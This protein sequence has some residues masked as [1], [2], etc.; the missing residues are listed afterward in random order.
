MS[1][2]SDPT[3]STASEDGAIA[4]P[5][6][7]GVGFPV[8]GLG[9]SAG[10]LQALIRFFELMPS[11]SG[12]AFVVVLHLSPRHESNLDQVLRGATRM[13]VMQVTQTVVIEKNCVYVISPAMRLTMLDGTLNVSPALEIAGRQTAIDLFFRTL[14]DAQKHHA[15]A[16]VLSGTGSDGAVGLKAVK[17]NGGVTIAQAPEDAL[18]DG[19]PRSAI[20]T[21]IID[22]VLPVSDMPQRL[23][24][25]AEN[26]RYI[27][28]PT[29]PE[30]FVTSSDRATALGDILSLLR[31]RTGHDFSQY[32][33]ATVL[34][35]LERR[36]QVTQTRDLAAYR[37]YLR[38]NASESQALLKD[39]LISVT[40][41]FRDKDAFDALEKNVLP[42]ICE[43]RESS[44]QVRIWVLGCATGEEAYSIAMLMAECASRYASPPQVQIFATDIDHDAIEVA[45]AGLYPEAIEAD[46][47]PERLKR[48]F[49]RE[50]NGYRISRAVRETVMFALHDVLKDPPF[51]RVD[52][53]ACRNL[54]I[55]LNS[56]VKT[57]VLQLLHFA[58]RPEGFLF[59]GNSEAIDETLGY[60][61]TFD[62]AARIYRPSPRRT[63]VTLP[64]LGRGVTAQT[65]DVT[66]PTGPRR[67]T[68][69]GELHHAMLEQY[70]PPS[71]IVNEQFDIVHLSPSSGRLLRFAGGEATLNLLKVVDDD[72]RVELRMG[73]YQALQTG[74]R[75]E[76]DVRRGDA[77]GKFVRVSIRPAVDPAT[78]RLFL[79]VIFHDT[80]ELHDAAA[81]TATTEATPVVDQLERELHAVRQQL[82]ATIDQYETQTEEL[83]ASNEELQ[84]INEELRSA[85]EELETGQEELQSTNEELH[86][87][88]QELKVRIEETTTTNNDLQNFIASTNIAVLFVNRDLRLMRFTPPAREIFNLLDGDVGRPLLDITS[89]ID[90]PQLEEDMRNVMASLQSNEREVVGDNGRA[91][92]ARTLPYRTTEDKID[93]A[94]VTFVEITARKG[95]EAQLRRN[96]ER[97]QLLMSSVRDYAMFTMAKDGSIDSWNAGAQR[98]FGWAEHEI[99]NQPAD[100]LF[101]PE[102]RAAGMP[103]EEMASAIENGRAA[104]ERF[105]VRKDGSR[106]YCSGIMTP[107]Y[108]GGTLYGFVKIARDIT[109]QHDAAQRRDEMLSAERINRSAAEQAIRTKDEFLATL[110]H[111]L[112]NPL[113][114]ILMQ[115]ELLLRASELHEVPKLKRA[116]EIIHQTVTA[117][118]Q[119]VDD[120][121]DMSRAKTGKLAINQQLLPLPFIIADSIGALKQDAELKQVALEMD[122]TAEPLIVAADAVRI[123]QIAWNLISNAIKFT[124]SGGRV[125][126][127]LRREANDARLDV[128]DT[129]QGIPPEM[130]AHIFDWF[131]Q[132]DTGS[133]RR[134]GGMGIGLALVR[135]LVELQGGRVAA[136]SEGKGKGA[137]FTVWMP[138]H[139]TAV[140]TA[141]ALPA[142]HQSSAE[143]KGT[144]LLLV[145]D[146]TAGANS[147]RDLLE[148]EGASVDAATSGAQALALAKDQ[149]YDI[150]ISD[151]E[152]PEMDG[153]TMLRRLRAYPSNKDT[154]AIAYTGYGRPQDLQRSKASGFNR[155]LTKPLDLTT[156]IEAIKALVK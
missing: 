58:L 80:P 26:A 9:A 94:V 152:M 2:P 104:D 134:Q 126:V 129:G 83:K 141:P 33:R 52:L 46:V 85:T 39:M 90:Y 55:Y 115:T 43:G 132:A 86:T 70:A 24:Q 109:E 36:M 38:A 92:L 131:R 151:I 123:K 28:L 45:R 82:R 156:L 50:P 153:H 4:A 135:Q 95:I 114:L 122:M 60:Y 103:Q 56:E 53:V 6:L 27:K 78:R 35:R 76:L 12:M 106:F 57:K 116:A 48:F 140:T 107:L 139:E 23:L 133:T 125:L 74:R 44:D 88:N 142:P 20:A 138:L 22:F 154:P 14:A 49:T 75:V 136:A 97:L 41:F 91:Y 3:E 47:S 11:D 63:G 99:L 77:T 68:T 54:L 31:T 32:K 96:D 69:Y 29:L 64:V 155:H 147:L 51:S 8:I 127:R 150:V 19:M 37:E 108:Y 124:S 120:L 146:S 21:R 15:M 145:D 100:V 73:L 7:P 16:I 98:I 149:H 79:L 13:P 61:V 130:L 143:L 72:L 144:R 10:G 119:L 66:T 62:K 84:A 89:R 111:E 128:E 25:I 113:S 105:H 71:V 81:S 101:T 93:G 30:A 1:E 102:D 42:L 87:V 59:L 5:P 112:R 67:T 117:Q 121:L 148:L 118:A 65:V 137:R 34:R 40:N 18:Y 17:E 110:S